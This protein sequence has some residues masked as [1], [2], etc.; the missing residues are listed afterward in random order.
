[1]VRVQVGPLGRDRRFVV[2]SA[3]III[4]SAVVFTWMLTLGRWDLFAS[5]AF[6]N[7]FDV[8]AR[9]I[10]HGRLSVP[11]SS[12]AYEAFF[13]G[14]KAYT[15]FGIFPSLLRLPVL[16]LTNGFDGRLTSISMI[17]AYLIA[18]WS[19]VQL[20]RL[21][22]R[23]HRPH[24]DWSA[25]GLAVAVLTVA[26]LCLGSNLMFLS[27]GA[28]VYHEASLWGAAG[29]LASFAATL[30]FLI[31]RR[32]RSVVA[33]GAW[34]AVAWLSRGSVALA[35]TIALGLIGLSHLT[36]VRPVRVLA[37]LPGPVV[38]PQAKDD[39][40]GQRGLAA[41]DRDVVSALREGR[42]PLLAAALLS[43]AVAGALAF[44]A[45]NTVKF[46]SPTT[47][48]VE[49]QLRG[50]FPGR[51]AAVRAHGGLF[52]AR[53]VLPALVQ[54]VRPDLVRPTTTW[55]LT[56]FTYAQPPGHQVFDTVEPSAG[57][58]TTMPL[59]VA[60]GAVGA[61]TILRPSRSARASD[62]GQLRLAALRPLVLGAAVA[63]AFPL[64]LA[65]IAQRY[66]TDA[67]PLLMI[68]AAT[69]A[70]V[71]D[72]WL[73]ASVGRPRARRRA[74]VA[75]TAAGLLALAGIVT[76]TGLAWQ[77]QRFAIPPDDEARAA[78]IRTVQAVSRRLGTTPP[79]FVRADSLPARSSAREVLVLRN[80]DGLYWGQ[81]L[82]RWD[83]IEVGP[84]AGH[85]RLRVRLA[86]S[87]APQP[88]PLLAVGHT[89]QDAMVVAL[90]REPPDRVRILLV[91]QDR[92]VGRG[93]PVRLRVRHPTRVEIWAD[94]AQQSVDVTVDG[95][96]ALFTFI[97]APDPRSSRIGINPFGGTVTSRLHG[98]VARLPISRRT[99][100]D[101]TR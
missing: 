17:V 14:G 60:L 76:T 75:V 38:E 99:C 63:A 10:A 11:A 42:R 37:P 93:E 65:F 84:L 80:C 28:W 62:V 16:V 15:Y 87:A 49:K 5:R 22:H 78:G 64:P 2:I 54:S 101:L 8:Q 50:Q 21:V 53:L 4:V 91:R 57:V 69:G 95:R 88:E 83:P 34:A 18:L 44:S 70:T 96:A 77:F 81:E 90:R 67:V 32:G 66:L 45:V 27:S 71:A 46:G 25:A 98:A 33:A 92:V 23:L 30:R 58:L 86:P 9:A 1:M 19:C 29:V 56:R 59:L 79:A 13:I 6:S 35:P 73:A 52:S 55:P 89:A 72:G 40:E 47:T 12:L 74:P 48:P 36:A 68:A 97:A 85:H 24:A 82:G 51:K 20:I 41:V 39:E 61:V 26:A 43:S 100:R 94:P 3:A 7:V 31:D